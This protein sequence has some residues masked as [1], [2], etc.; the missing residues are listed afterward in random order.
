M[1][2]NNWRTPPR[3]PDTQDYVTV[4]KDGEE[5]RRLLACYEEV[6]TRGRE[7]RRAIPRLFENEAI[8]WVVGDVR[9]H[10][11]TIKAPNRR[12]DMPG[13]NSPEWD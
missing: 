10:I 3:R 1:A 5:Q 8:R 13:P 4:V 11:V 9:P 7:F 2:D 12:Y 6:G